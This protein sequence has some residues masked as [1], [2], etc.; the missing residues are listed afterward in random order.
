MPDPKPEN[1]IKNKAVELGFDLCGIAPVKT[2]REHGERLNSWL[3]NGMH[4]GMSYMARNKEKRLD[5][6]LLVKDARSVI[7]TAINY[8]Q[9]YNPA[10]DQPVFARYA[11][12]KDYHRVI[13]NKLYELFGII[14][15]MHPGAGGR[16]FVDTAP[17]LERA[18]AVEAGLGWIGRNSMLI[19]KKLG[20]FT[21]LGVIIVDL[22]F[23]YDKPFNKDYCGSCRKCIDACPAGA[24]N[25]DRTIDS[26]KCISYLTIEHHGELPHDLHRVSDNKVF[27][28]DICQ[29]VCPW[30]NNVPVTGIKEFQ[31]LPEILK[32]T[33]KQWEKIS[34]DDYNRIFE[35]SA[36]NRADYDGFL[37]NLSSISLVDK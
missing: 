6:G 11:L 28:C 24:I 27:G 7:V 20:S 10:K 21:F 35:N 17:V 2:L 8:Y 32:Y 18:W 16:V 5:P 19:N 33:V 13:K 23:S 15:E 4:A 31:P 14:K 34:G 22:K 37:R 25:E 3:A 29:E 36:V 30:N 12:G 26:N 1:I 9:T